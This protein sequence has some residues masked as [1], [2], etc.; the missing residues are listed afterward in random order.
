MHIMFH[1]LVYGRFSSFPS[2]YE[3]TYEPIF[4]MPQIERY[5]APTALRHF[6]TLG[7]I[8][9]ILETRQITKE[10]APHRS[11]ANGERDSGEM[12]GHRRE[13]EDRNAGNRGGKIDR[14]RQHGERQLLKTV[15]R[16]R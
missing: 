16:K 3:Y 5:R 1:C 6:L 15:L 7:P 13:A 2:L 8:V 9:Q 4:R 11:F 14:D 12:E 10:I